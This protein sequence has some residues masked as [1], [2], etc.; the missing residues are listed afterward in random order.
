MPPCPKAAPRADKVDAADIVSSL[1]RWHQTRG[2][3]FCSEVTCGRAR[4]GLYVPRMDGVAIANS[5][6]RREVTGYEVKVTRHDFRADDKIEAYLPWCNRLFVVSPEGV[7]HAGDV[8]LL[9]GVGLMHYRLGGSRD[10]TLARRRAMAR[11]TVVVGARRRA[12]DDG[13]IPWQLYHTLL[14]NK[15]TF[16]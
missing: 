12:F 11:L 15:A 7:L 13:Q 9:D 4:T 14:L 6:D 16:K 3:L 5:W 2:D 8:E 10:D 1:R